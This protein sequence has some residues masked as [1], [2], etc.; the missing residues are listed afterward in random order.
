MSNESIIN[1]K[2]EPAICTQCGSTI[3]VN[4]SLENAICKHCGTS[5]VVKKA[6]KNYNIQH[7]KVKHVESKTIQNNKR[8]AVESILNFMDKYILYIYISFLI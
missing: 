2:L 7:G 1:T 4:S 6:I 3:E 8:G 5:F